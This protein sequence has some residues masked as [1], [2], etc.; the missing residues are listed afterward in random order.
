MIAKLLWEHGLE[1]TESKETG[2]LKVSAEKL[3]VFGEWV[4]AQ[5]EI[6]NCIFFFDKELKFSLKKKLGMGVISIF[7]QDRKLFIIARKTITR[8]GSDLGATVLPSPV[9][10]DACSACSYKNGKMLVLKKTGIYVQNL[11][12]EANQ[13]SLVRF[14]NPKKVTAIAYNSQ[15]DEIAVTS[16]ADNYCEIY[17]GGNSENTARLGG[18]D[19]ARKLILHSPRECVFWKNN[20]ILADA[21]NDS[22]SIYDSSDYTAPARTILSVQG[23][24]GEVANLWRPVAVTCDKAGTM[25]ISDTKNQRII[26][27]NQTGQELAA[28]G[29]PLVLRRGLRLPRGLQVYN[30]TLY[31]CDSHNDRVQQLDLENGQFLQT[32]YDDVSWPRQTLQLKQ[33]NIIVSAQAAAYLSATPNAVY[34]LPGGVGKEALRDPHQLIADD[35]GFISVNSGMNTVT[36]YD[37]N[38]DKIFKYEQ[39]AGLNLDDP[40]SSDFQFGEGIVIADT[41]NDRIIFLQGSAVRIVKEFTYRGE[42]IRLRQPRFVCRHEKDKY[43]VIDTGTRCIYQID[44]HGNCYWILGDR[45]RHKLIAPAKFYEWQEK[46][47]H[48]P[49]YIVAS[50]KNMIIVADTGNSR[51]VK[52]NISSCI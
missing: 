29:K 25:F 52:I 27:I 21:N 42:T 50:E 3:A 28:T 1:Y 31:V 40:H 12:P 2:T 22:L 32:I 4:V 34:A 45:R 9:G 13:I 49:R 20:L 35:K 37:S 15:T 10:E 26:G 38:G 11:E 47:F 30:D 14:K 41:G 16:A 17:Q 8:I 33:H 36:L 18:L 46:M 6:T 24:S 19:A 48:D 7:V 39:I 51:I 23:R 44:E 43:L 5:E